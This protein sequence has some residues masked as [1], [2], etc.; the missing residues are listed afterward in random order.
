VQIEL[1]TL[2]S[3]VAVYARKITFRIIPFKIHHTVFRGPGTPGLGYDKLKEIIRKEYNYIYS[4]ENT[5]VLGFNIQ[6]NNLAF[7]GIA[8]LTQARDQQANTNPNQSGISEG[9]IEEVA[10]NPGS[11]LNAQR[12]KLGNTGR[13][14]KKYT[15]DF[16]GGATPTGTA[17]AIADAFGNAALENA[18][19]ELVVVDLEI[20]G[21]MYFL[22]QNELSNNFSRQAGGLILEDGTMNSFD[23][24]GYIYIRFRTPADINEDTSLY[25][26]PRG[27]KEN[28]FSGIYRVISVENIFEEGV[29]KQ[30]LKCNRMPNQPQDYDEE[31]IANKDTGFRFFDA[32]STKGKTGVTEE[33]TKIC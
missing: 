32:G 21:D 5:D 3:L 17:R 7:S 8:N 1:T 19:T 23:S 18:N 4:G 29:F 16:K 31:V 14:R 24:D 26:F 9:N 22:Q 33:N 2:D 25:E 20:L 11:G 27:G 15:R 13:P 28:Y 12:S 6:I 30:V 10:T